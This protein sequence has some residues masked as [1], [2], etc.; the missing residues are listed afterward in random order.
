MGWLGS[1]SFLY[2]GALAFFALTPLLVLAYLTRERPRRIRV[3]S[4]LAYRGLSGLKARR[5]GGWPRLNWLF[6]VELLILCLAVLAMAGP[7]VI[8][9]SHEI[10]VVLDNSAA[11]QVRMPNGTTRFDAAVAKIKSELG[12]QNSANRIAVYVTAPQPHALAAVFDSPGQARSA[13]SSLKPADAP[14]DPGSV[15]ALLSELTSNA[16][17][18]AVFYAGAA[19]IAPPPP[20]RLHAD[21]FDASSANYALSSFTLC[22]ESF[23]SP[24]LHV[25]VG[26]ANFSPSAR[27]LKVSIK[28]NGR[29]LGNAEKRLTPN[30]VGAIDF[31]KLPI[32]G[33][34]RANLQ[35]ADGFALDNTAYAAASAVKSTVVLFVSPSPSDAAGLGALPGVKVISRTPHKYTPSD[36]AL[37]DVAIFEYS[38]PKDLPG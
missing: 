23:G 8:H 34:Y 38:V 13:I 6:F 20:S 9:R 12:R 36:L 27:T 17:F 25:R 32:A 22:R 21:V 19:P 26:V 2:P 11:M 1:L 37:A 4:V 33:V 28:A 18:S 31:P 29:V 35:P 15:R 30:E 7:Y 3:S 10:A 16:K 5:L 14:A 24:T